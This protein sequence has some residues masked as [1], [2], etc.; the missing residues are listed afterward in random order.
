M[1]RHLAFSLLF[2]ASLFGQAR[3]TAL[4]S[5]EAFMTEIVNK[6]WECT[7]TNYPELRFHAYKI[8]ILDSSERITTT[9]T[10]LKHV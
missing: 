10:K 1:L 8:E 4:S 9:L 3:H 7:F 2:A 6:K 5:H